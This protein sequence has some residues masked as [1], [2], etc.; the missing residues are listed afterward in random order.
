MVGCMAGRQASMCPSPP[1]DDLRGR[2]WSTICFGDEKRGEEKERV[3]SDLD[4][5]S[6]RGF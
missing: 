6:L 3:D 1:D 5:R 2:E 4:R